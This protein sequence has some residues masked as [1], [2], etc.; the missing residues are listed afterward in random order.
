M[1]DPDGETYTD[2]MRTNV[3]RDKDKWKFN[4]KHATTK[5]KSWEEQSDQT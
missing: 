1:I 3:Q 5:W 2:M 4:K